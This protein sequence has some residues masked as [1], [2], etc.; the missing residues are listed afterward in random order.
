MKAI[1]AKCS[2]YFSQKIL[3]TAL[4]AAINAPSAQ[5]GCTVTGTTSVFQCDSSAVQVYADP[6]TVSLVV[7]GLTTSS[8]ELRPSVSPTGSYD[9]F[10]TLTGNTVINNPYYSGVIMQ[11]S[12]ANRNVTVNTSATVS[13]T[14]GDGF[15]GIWVRNDTSGNISI[16][17]A[18]TVTATT[19]TLYPSGPADGI[20]ATTNL[21]SVYI[22]NSGTVTSL[23]NR[24]LYGDGG[25]NNTGSDLATVQIINSG[26]VNAYQAGIRAINYYGLAAIE[27]SGTVSSSRRQGLV[28]WS[29]SG[30]VSITN[31][32]T[33]SSNDDNAIHAMTEIGNITVVNSGTLSAANNPSVSTSSTVGFS[34][35]WAEVDMDPTATGSTGNINIT[36]TSAGHI[37]TPDDYA[38][39]ARTPLG[40]INIS[41][42]GTLSGLGGIEATN[43]AGNVTISNSGQITASGTSSAG[44][45]VVTATGGSITNSG[46]VSGANYAL[47][48]DSGALLTSGVTNTSSGKLIGG[49][50]IDSATDLTNNGV[51]ALKT[52]TDL[53]NIANTGVATQGT[54]GG[55]FTQST[56][57]SLYLA[58][59]GLTAGSY[60]ALAVA[61][62]ANV[63]GTLDVDVKSGLASSGTLASVISSS[64]LTN[65]ITRVTDNSLRY[66]FQAVTNGNNVDLVVTDTG[67]TSIAQGISSNPGSA[68]GAAQVLDAASNS[69]N[70][71]L[72][73]VIHELNSSTSSADLVGKVNQ[74]LPLLVGNTQTST[75]A[76]LAGI[77]R[78][79]QARLEANQGLSSGEEFYGDKYFWMKPFAS[80]AVQGEKDGMAGYK[81]NTYGIVAG[82]DWNWSPSLNLG[83]A[84]AYAKSDVNGSNTNS[85][86]SADIDIY[87]LIGYGSY[88]IDAQT[89]INFQAD[90][91]Q[92]NTDGRRRI[93]FM[94]SEAQSSYSGQGVHVGAGI[95]RSYPLSSRSTITPSIRFDYTKIKDDAYVER[96]AG[97]L[98]LNVNSRTGEALVIAAS[99]KI[100]H[101]LND[102]L[103]LIGKAG[104]GYDAINKRAAI[105]SAFAGSPDASFVTYGIDSS[106]WLVQA[107]LGLAYKAKDQLE[108]TGQY[109]VDYRDSY[110]NQTASVKLRWLF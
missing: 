44:I 47:R 48:V 38:I 53:S 5:A 64:A 32:G 110:L 78:V 84:F 109:D 13:I 56:G 90:Y 31:S 71:A 103:S 73:G 55:N 60:S 18:A 106:P 99:S 21:G 20:H 108:I 86:Q 66:A 58:A 12:L 82:I 62:S 85:Q 105:T 52:G 100:I 80:R 29:N 94:S 14:S 1:E 33:V 61:G 45:A 11:S 95:G 59:N 2:Q 96:G 28:A 51:I 3:V 79:I 39:V 97:A 35:I 40:D 70:A 89:E 36:N 17:N 72:Q 75:L 87:R 16:N 43:S 46:T 26:T 8:V 67:M 57:G 76:S 83:A 101:R 68:G 7:D 30:P 10:L 22:N 24:G 41:N 27:N 49:L 42:S 93:S 9:Q 102:D 98:N 6:G 15:G 37:S 4:L 88:A 91:G 23:T 50:R 81:A 69:G 19:G 54:I 104:I 34:G 77:N 65:N 63:S 92:N 25:Y 74:T 107:G